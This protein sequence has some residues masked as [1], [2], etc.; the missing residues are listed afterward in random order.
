MIRTQ[1]YLQKKERDLLKQEAAR[2]NITMAKLVRML[3]TEYAYRKKP[4]ASKIKAGD[5]LLGL[6][7]LARERGY[8]GPKN[9]A[10]DSDKYLYGK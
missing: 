9:L 10:R 6:S 7:D 4:P 5:F 3:V 2:K 8:R 1:I